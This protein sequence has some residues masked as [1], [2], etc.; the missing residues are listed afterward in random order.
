SIQQWHY[1]YDGYDSSPLGEMD[2]APGA[3]EGAL[4]DPPDLL[5]QKLRISV[6]SPDGNVTRTIEV[7]K[8]DV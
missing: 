2:W 3:C 6:T 5:V 7:V 1:A 4:T 8:S